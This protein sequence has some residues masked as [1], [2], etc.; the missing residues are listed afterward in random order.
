VISATCKEGTGKPP[1]K[2]LR[3]KQKMAALDAVSQTC[4]KTVDKSV[5]QMP[6]QESLLQTMMDKSFHLM[7]Q[8]EP[9]LQ[10]MMMHHKSLD[11]AL[12][13]NWPIT[14]DAAA[15]H[16]VDCN[17]T[18]DVFAFDNIEKVTVPESRRLV[19]TPGS[20]AAVT[21]T[22]AKEAATSDGV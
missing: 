21:A 22:G 15:E 7:M 9:L 19:P 4:L 10:T 8:Q 2:W 20:M 12:A 18:Q 5:H 3:P 11:V 1:Y 16:I 17:T 6:Q 13:V 14:G